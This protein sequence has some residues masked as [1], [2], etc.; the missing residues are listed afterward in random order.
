M[1]NMNGDVIEQLVQ[2][3]FKD[4]D[5]L[6]R[7]LETLLQ[8]TMQSEVSQH[9]GAERHQRSERRSGH[10]LFCSYRYLRSG[11]ALRAMPDRCRPL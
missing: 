10:R 1:A 2:E 11:V 3:V 9:I 8:A 4:R 5:G 6:K 7:L